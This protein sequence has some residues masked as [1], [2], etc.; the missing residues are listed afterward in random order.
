MVFYANLWYNKALNNA[1][2]ERCRKH[3]QAW[4]N[5]IRRFVLDTLPPRE[6]NDNV[7]LPKA[8]G[9]YKI[10]CAAN[11]KIYIGS[12]LD[13]Q[14]RRADHLRDLRKNRHVNSYLQRAFNK[15]GQEAFT[16]EVLEL[17]LLP[18]MLTAREQCW[19]DKLKPFGKRGFNIL[20]KAGSALG[21]RHTSEA[22]ARISKANTGRERSTE[23]LER[24]SASHRGKPSTFKGKK[25]T[26][27]AREKL[28]RARA[29][30]KMLPRA[31]KPNAYRTDG[32]VSYITLTLGQEA[33]IDTL[34]LENALKVRWRAAYDRRTGN[35]RAQG[36]FH[37]EIMFLNRYLTRAK[38]GEWI[39]HLNLNTLDNRRENLCLRNNHSHLSALGISSTGF[40]GITIY[41]K[42]RNNR[43]EST[44]Y[45]FTCQCKACRITKYFPYTEEGLEAARIFAEVHYAAMNKET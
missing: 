27:E 44:T 10:A 1:K 30:Q 45:K 18:E 42:K 41:K 12:A 26:P 4:T 29:N 22:I 31:V 11:E 39:D 40:R 7:S 16:F 9:I 20:I 6:H 34:D 13:L 36:S 25:H 21:Y 19:L 43:I 17:V 14:R 28:K 2:P 33:I 15:Y 3:P 8:P 5:P 38:E 24:Q 32:G 23:T 35:Y 37:G